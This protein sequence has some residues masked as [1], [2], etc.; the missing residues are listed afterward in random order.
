MA[1]A[2]MPLWDMNKAGGATAIVPG[3]HKEENV[4]AI[5]EYR[6]SLWKTVDK[7]DGSGKERVWQGE[8][9]PEEAM[10]QYTSIGLT[11]CVTNVIAGDLVL[12]DTA[13]CAAAAPPS[14]QRTSDSCSGRYHAGCAAE[15]PSGLSS[16]GPDHLLRAIFILSM[17]PTRLLTTFWGEEAVPELF[18][19]RRRAYELDQ[20]IVRP[21]SPHDGQGFSQS[22][23]GA[24][25]LVHDA[26][27]VDLA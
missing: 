19:A 20:H 3:S 17:A 25:R 6:R 9:R 27:A 1:D 24:G 4:K 16:H 26:R 21:P 12:F 2:I 7:A 5:E 18:R 11:P 15:D 22:D 14:P 10:E 23:A 8:G 13:M